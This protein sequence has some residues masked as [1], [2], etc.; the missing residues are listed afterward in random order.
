MGNKCPNDHMDRPSHEHYVYSC[1]E[2]NIKY[3][4]DILYNCPRASQSS[5]LSMW[6]NYCNFTVKN[7]DCKRLLISILD[8][9]DTPPYVNGYGSSIADLEDRYKLR[10]YVDDLGINQRRT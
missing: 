8:D 10:K 4:G 7:K 3:H 6:S 1:C 5:K 9:G 2:H